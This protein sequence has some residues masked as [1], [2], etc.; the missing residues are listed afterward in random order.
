M[1]PK[2]CKRLGLPGIHGHGH[3]LFRSI[4]SPENSETSKEAALL[5]SIADICKSEINHGGMTNLWRDDLTLP[6]FPYLSDDDDY[7]KPKLPERRLDSLYSLITTPVAAD[8]FYPANRI[9]S[10]SVDHTPKGVESLRPA[11]NDSPLPSV[12]TPTARSPPSRHRNHGRHASTRLSVKA[13]RDTLQENRLYSPPS[14]PKSKRSKPLQGIPPKGFVGKKIGR[15]KFSWKNYPEVRLM[16]QSII[17]T[18]SLD[19]TLSTFYFL[20]S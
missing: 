18:M 8:Q 4:S 12:V 7:D 10:V 2:L 15:K 19:L 5:L 16:V 6:S 3:T 9:R 20:C 14:T 11:T 1:N 17:L 13:K